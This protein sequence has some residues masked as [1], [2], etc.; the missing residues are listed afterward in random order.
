MTVR[1]LI[2][3]LLLLPLAGC[4]MPTTPTV[5]TVGDLAQAIE[6]NLAG[7][8]RAVA[9]SWAPAD[10]S[11]ADAGFDMTLG[12]G[13]PAFM[14]DVAA[15]AALV[16]DAA[17]TYRRQVEGDQVYTL[18]TPG[19]GEA[20][21]VR[22]LGTDGITWIRANGDEMQL[23]PDHLSFESG[24]LALYLDDDMMRIQLGGASLLEFERC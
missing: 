13:R 5:W 9:G 20:T 23:F 11:C 19:G 12:A 7:V 4:A 15:L 3:L 22:D 6:A 16:P 10:G 2:R 21:L 18:A 14:P 24:R 1:P 17:L 8:A